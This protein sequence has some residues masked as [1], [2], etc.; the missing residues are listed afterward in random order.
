MGL[1]Q[2]PKILMIHLKRFDLITDPRTGH[3][4]QEKL[5][6]FVRFPLKDFDIRPFLENKEL[7]NQKNPILYD[8]YAVSNHY[9]TLNGGHYTAFGFNSD[10]NIW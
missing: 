3:Q 9:G 10:K 5:N 4:R 1:Y 7:K 8:L 6:D 2:L